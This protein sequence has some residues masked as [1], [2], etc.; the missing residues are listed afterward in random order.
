MTPAQI[1]KLAIIIWN[2]ILVSLFIGMTIYFLGPNV[3]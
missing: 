3:R 1:Y 2:F